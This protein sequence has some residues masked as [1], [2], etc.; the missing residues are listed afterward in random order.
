MIVAKPRQRGLELQRLVDR[1]V[2][3]LLDDVLAPR[4]ERAPAEAAGE[5]LDSG[6]ADAMN[7]GGVA[8][9]DDH[10]G[11]GQDLG[12]LVLL[13]G[14]EVVIAEHALRWES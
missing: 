11:V 10:P 2:H 6:E 4:P 3:E 14:L 9:E 13:A 1:F 5:T 12:D 8:V 7:L